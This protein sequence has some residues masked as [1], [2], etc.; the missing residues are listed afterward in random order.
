MAPVAL[1]RELTSC[2]VAAAT[3]WADDAERPASRTHRLAHPAKPFFLGI[4]DDARAPAQRAADARPAPAGPGPRHGVWRFCPGPVRGAARA[5]ADARRSSATCGVAGPSAG[6]NRHVDLLDAQS[7]IKPY[8]FK[9]RVLA[10]GTRDYGEDVAER[11]LGQNAA[12]LTNPAV[13][14]YYA[15]L[16]VPDRP[17][18]KA[19]RRPKSME[20][21]SL[22]SHP[23]PAL[24]HADPQR[25]RRG[26]ARDEGS[27]RRRARR[28]PSL[29]VPPAPHGWKPPPSRRLADRA[30][31][32]QREAR[33]DAAAE[34]S[35]PRSRSASP[36]HVPR[37]RARKS[38]PVPALRGQRTRPGQGGDAGRLARTPST[39][40]SRASR[41]PDT[42][43]GSGVPRR[44]KLG[45]SRWPDSSS[46]EESADDW[47]P[48]PRSLDPRASPSAGGRRADEA[49]AGISSRRTGARPASV[50]SSEGVRTSRSSEKMHSPWQGHWH[51]ARR[52]G[53]CSR[54]ASASGSQDGSCKSGTSA[55]ALTMDIAGHVPDRRSS[56]KHMSLSSMTPTTEL[57]D[58]SS[59]F[60]VRPR[61]IHT[62]NTSIDMAS[63]TSPANLPGLKESPSGSSEGGDGPVGSPWPAAL[64]HADTDTTVVSK[65]WTPAGPGGARFGGE[66]EDDDAYSDFGS[67]LC[68]DVGSGGEQRRHLDDESTLFELGGHDDL[69]NNLPGLLE[70][71]ATSPCLVCSLL[72][73]AATG[74][75]SDDKSAGLSSRGARCGHR[76]LS[77]RRE[78]LRAL[79]YEYD[80]DNSDLEPPHDVRRRA[81]ARDAE[82]SGTLRGR[83]DEAAA[84]EWRSP[85][86]AATAAR[87]GP[88]GRGKRMEGRGGHGGFAPV[89]E[90]YEEGHAAD[91]E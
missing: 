66:Q 77:S 55:R 70:G 80:T 27:P 65:V 57:S 88:R 82:T 9:S 29:E 21:F 32:K 1:G 47:A 83:T 64:D 85:G 54:G 67:V 19:R 63:L 44:D 30:S 53:R 15:A 3:P 36:P 59:I 16:G 7:E 51:H 6:A 11:N 18:A 76:G 75:A 74:S 22:S 8:D 43:L 20:S 28:G 35:G 81:R 17:A 39:A 56:L 2:D 40:P 89:L 91:V 25:G 33:G 12:D 73:G 69:G 49:A 42:S 41:G 26:R 72:R 46:E 45:T 14:V 10:T 31:E 37:Y 50:R 34:G 84:E 60:A 58:H 52:D 13:Q 87:R 71:A 23:D 86:A 61:S 79:G 38:Q 90:D 62:A 48:P 68:S 5:D 4:R 78:R 24:V